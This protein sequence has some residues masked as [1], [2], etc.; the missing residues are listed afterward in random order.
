MKKFISNN[1][2]K[3]INTILKLLGNL[4]KFLNRKNKIN[5][6]KILLLISFC[7]LSEIISIGSI[8]PFLNGL[9]DAKNIRYS[10]FLNLQLFD[11]ISQSQLVILFGITFIFISFLNAFLRILNIKK[12]SE[13]NCKIT[14]KLNETIYKKII[15][16]PYINLVKMNSSSIINNI[17]VDVP[18]VS[19]IITNIFQ[20]FTSIIICLLIIIGLIIFNWKITV[21]SILFFCFFYTLINNFVSKKVKLNGKKIA[22]NNKKQIKFVQESFGSVREIKL[23]SFQNKNQKSFHEIEYPLRKLQ[24]ENIFMIQSPR[25]LLESFTLTLIIVLTLILTF[26]SPTNSAP[27]TLLSVFALASQKLLPLFQQVFSSFSIIIANQ[28]HLK[29]A[30][31]LLKIKNYDDSKIEDKSPINFE[32][33]F[34]LR[35]VFFKYSNDSKYILK[36]ISLKIFKGEKIGLIGKTG[37][38]K[39]TLINIIIGLFNPRKGGFYLDNKKFRNEH[40]SIEYRNW[41]S[42]ISYVP[43]NIY[44]SDETFLQ[45]ISFTNKTEDINITEVEEAAKKA[46]ILDFILESPDGFNTKLGERGISLSGGQRQRVGLAR[47]FYKNPE[48]LV[49]DEATSALD[50]KTESKVMKTIYNQKNEI[51]MIIIAHRT[52]TL[53]NCDRVLELTENGLIEVEKENL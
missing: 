26:S 42:L 30:I 11:S 23:N 12:S 49:L 39:S 3:E 17:N 34:E 25:Y 51:T 1:K 47:A 9:I 14:S 36:N 33:S 4:F 2:F 43:Q 8:I 35:D 20:L 31:E 19:L 50:S 32:E 46:N 52:S 24:T 27:I 16:S 38:G 6:F 45:N 48:I 41:Q 28:E 10:N 18:R 5:F 22:S 15:N 53:K 44:L 13:F 29:N 21:Y 37:V 7:G 40:N